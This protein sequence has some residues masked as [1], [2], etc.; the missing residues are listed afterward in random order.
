MSRRNVLITLISAVALIA[1]VIVF[2]AIIPRGTLLLSVAPEEFTITINGKNHNKKTGEKI[3][4]EPG[5]IKLAISREGF[6]TLE[7]TLTVKNREEIEI[8]EAL[9]PKTDEARELLKTEKSQAILQRLRVNET[10]TEAEDLTKTYPL[11]KELPINDKYYTVAACPSEKFP[12]DASKVA[13]CVLLYEP[14]AKPYVDDDIKA[15]GYD[16][17]KYEVI[18]SDQ[19]YRPGTSAGGGD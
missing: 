1:I 7:K 8:L 3:N 13:I 11:I 16:L 2:Y 15:R 6:E 9:T 19:S 12:N 5:E 10:N 14:A 18:Y 4:V 17:S